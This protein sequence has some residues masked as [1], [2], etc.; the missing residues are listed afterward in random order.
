MLDVIN[1]FC[2]GTEDTQ[3]YCVALNRI[4]EVFFDQFV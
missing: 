3:E 2:N 4:F 1:I